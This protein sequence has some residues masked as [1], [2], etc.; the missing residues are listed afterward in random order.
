L[1]RVSAVIFDLDNVLYDEQDYIKAA[2][3]NI[4]IFLSKR[5]RLQEEQIYKKLLDDLKKKTSLYPHL[6]DDFLTNF[7]LDKRL[8]SNM[9]RIY[10]NTTVNLALYSGADQLL[11]ALKQQKIKSGLV[12]NGDVETQRNKVHLLGIEKYFDTIL[13]TREFGKGNEKP[14]PEAYRKTLRVL[15]VHPEEVVC[16]GDNPHTDFF[17]AKKLGIRTVRLLSGEFRNVRLSADYE[18]DITVRNFKELSN[19]IAQSI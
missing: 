16:V 9:L 12:T 10:A 18:A 15:N 5:C 1:A 13:Y 8:V 11:S 19:I 4:A 6:F 3:R 2:Y 17:G 7:G 14:N